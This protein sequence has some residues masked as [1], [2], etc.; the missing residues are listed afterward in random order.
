MSHTYTPSHPTPFS[1]CP[2]LPLEARGPRGQVASTGWWEQAR[3]RGQPHHRDLSVEKPGEGDRR[4][5]G[6]VGKEAGD[7]EGWARLTSVFS[8][9]KS[10]PETSL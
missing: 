8:S 3:S 7:E 1:L 6:R 5:A 4:L 9:E 10:E 2:E